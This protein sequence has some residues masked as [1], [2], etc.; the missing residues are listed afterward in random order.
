MT[1]DEAVAGVA[2]A[3]GWDT[4]VALIRTI[5]EHF[6]TLALQGGAC[7]QI[8][9]ATSS[10]RGDIIED[11]VAGVF[12][13]NG[14][15]Y[16]RTGSHNQAEIASRFNLTVKPAPDFVVYDSAGTLR[17]IL[18]CKAANDGGTARD[19]AARFQSLRT[20]AIRLGGIPLLAVLAGLGWTRT[21]DALGPVV[22]DTDGR[23]F[24]MRTLSQLM[25]VQPFAS[26]NKT[27][28]IS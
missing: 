21:S 12:D 10:K 9:D 3:T 20:E 23:V 15:Q 1:A 7:R 8:L 6:G 19:K 26:M 16:V 18:E 17:T 13:D 25:E 24:T 5:P 27:N 2:A 22:R 4:R 11:A 14:I 28:Q